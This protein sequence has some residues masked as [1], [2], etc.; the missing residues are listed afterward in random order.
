MWIDEQFTRTP[1]SFQQV[2][3]KN[4]LPHEFRVHYFRVIKNITFSADERVIE[5]AREEARR[6]KTTLN[7]LFREWLAELAARDER[8]RKIERLMEDMNQY[9]AGRPFTRDEMN[10]L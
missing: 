8:K 3:K 1:V 6:R 5:E 4:T 7:V 9:N 2:N 10:R